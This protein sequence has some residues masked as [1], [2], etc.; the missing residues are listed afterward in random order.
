MPCNFIHDDNGLRMIICTR[1]KPKVQYCN[2]GKKA[3]AFC[4]AP[5]NVDG[6]IKDCNKPLCNEHRIK[7]GND[8][9]VCEE[10]NNEESILLAKISRGLEV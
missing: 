9:D 2:C 4:D 7:I 6:V 5:V 1:G 10:H 8:T 3:V